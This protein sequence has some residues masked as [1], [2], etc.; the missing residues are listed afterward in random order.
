[1]PHTL[2]RTLRYSDYGAFA[3]TSGAIGTWVFT[4]N[5][6]YDPD[7]TFSGHQPF[8]F[9][10]LMAFYTSFTVLSA[11]ITCD[12]IAVSVPIFL[13]VTASTSSSAVYASYGSYIES[14]LS[15]Y[16]FLDDPTPGTNRVSTTVDIA[17]FLGKVDLVDDPTLSGTSS[18]NPSS[19]VYFHVIAQDVNKTSTANAEVN[20][21][22]DYDI[23]FHGP[24]TLTT[25]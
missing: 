24:K 4:A 3:G 7:V 16:R 1:M 21:I 23:V 19:L 17:R 13:G 25:S 11:R 22:V 10:Q 18:S 14:G 12:A 9:D 6:L 20:T 8:G 15:S 5:G 2:R